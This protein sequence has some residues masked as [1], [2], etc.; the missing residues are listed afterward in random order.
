MK[1]TIGIMDLDWKKQYAE[2]EI[3]GRLR[4]TFE[5][6]KNGLQKTIF[7]Y[8]V[9]ISEI[10][11]FSPYY[12]FPIMYLVYFAFGSIKLTNLPYP[13]NES[14]IFVII[15][16]IF[17]FM[18]AYVSTKAFK[19]NDFLYYQSQKSSNIGKLIQAS[20]FISIVGAIIAMT[21]QTIFYGVP[22]LDPGIRLAMSPKIL[23][24]LIVLPLSLNYYLSIRLNDAISD[25]LK[26]TYIVFIFAIGII[27]SLFTAYRILV[28]VFLLTFIVIINVSF[29]KIR[30]IYLSMAG[31]ILGLLIVGLQQYRL[32]RTI[33]SSSFDYLN[34]HGYPN[35]LIAAHL[36][37]HEGATV[38]SDIVSLSPLYGWLHGQFF[39]MSLEVIKPGIQLGPG[40]FISLVRGTNL[41]SGTTSSILGGPYLDFGIFGIM[42]FMSLVGFALMLLY[43][44]MK[45]TK[46]GTFS[47]SVG[48]VS[49]AY[50]L[51]I[52][53]VSI[54]ID[55]YSITIS[56]MSLFLVIFLQIIVSKWYKNGKILA[57]T[58]L[59]IISAFAIILTPNMFSETK[60]ESS[61]I[62]FCAT[63]LNDGKMILVDK[64][65]ART[66][67]TSK[68]NIFSLIDYYSTNSNI[69]NI[70]KNHSKM[71]IGYIFLNK[72][73]PI[74]KSELP[75][76]INDIAINN[77]YA[78]DDIN[79]YDMNY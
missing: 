19:H 10:D 46:A 76:E 51:A 66:G 41:G 77:I 54:H 18:G 23:S 53:I 55:L 48:V 5:N 57:I 78:S 11:L 33:G 7:P 24:V 74:L 21:I 35:I 34:P 25:R 12:L 32:Q 62:K 1:P 67:L 13:S 71:N 75:E 28:V 43:N 8:A 50:S 6:M 59:I 58:G 44:N 4:S 79:I 60:I 30:P 37:C 20:I 9:K 42:L 27:T 15:G 2:V 64:Y 68:D 3:L 63:N 26:M 14:K 16:I 31:F 49:Y 38:F 17:Y 36:S 56:M 69:L 29:R 39:R 65:S 45:C 52:F 40:S 70:L 22:L 73:A 72:R 61:A 47:N